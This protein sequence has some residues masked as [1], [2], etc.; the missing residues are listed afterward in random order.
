[1]E[2]VEDGTVGGGE[3]SEG[4][5]N[6]YNQDGKQRS[7]WLITSPAFFLPSSFQ[8]LS[9]VHYKRHAQKEPMKELR[10]CSKSQIMATLVTS[11]LEMLTRSRL[12]YMT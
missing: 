9:P 2:V 4:E 1:M 8:A 10:R 11:R 5:R 7:V 6:W 12:L 3:N